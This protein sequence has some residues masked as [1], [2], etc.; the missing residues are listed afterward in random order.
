[1]MEYESRRTVATC[2]GLLYGMLRKGG[3]TKT[4]EVIE[5]G[6]TEC[7]ATMINIRKVE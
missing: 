1:M 4:V 3:E 2:R 7:E 5:P 6:S